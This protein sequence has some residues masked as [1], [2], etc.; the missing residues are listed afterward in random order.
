MVSTVF[1]SNVGVGCFGGWLE[2]SVTGDGVVGGGD[3][4]VVLG[5]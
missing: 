2:W 3:R 4:H 5:V 1:P